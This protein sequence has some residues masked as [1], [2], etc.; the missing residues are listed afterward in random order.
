L[1]KAFSKLMGNYMTIESGWPI[2]AA[3]ALMGT[4]GETFNSSGHASNPIGFHDLVK[5]WDTQNAVMWAVA[6]TS[7]DGIIGGKAYSMINA[8]TLSNG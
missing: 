4:W 6:N 3:T 1:E 5:D 2:D 7:L 8:V